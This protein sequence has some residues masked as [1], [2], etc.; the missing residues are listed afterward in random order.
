[1]K[2]LKNVGPTGFNS[3]SPHSHLYQTREMVD[4][5]STS[6]SSI[7]F[8]PLSLQPNRALIE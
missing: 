3:L 1:V 4:F 2:I 7:S 6:L 5:S 8:S